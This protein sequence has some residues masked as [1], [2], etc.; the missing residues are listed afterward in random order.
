MPAK[1]Q[2]F[3]PA[4]FSYLYAEEPEMSEVTE[5]HILSLGSGTIDP[6]VTVVGVGGAGSNIVNALKEHV[7]GIETVAVNTDA[8]HLFALDTDKKILIGKS[9]TKCFSAHNPGIGTWAAMSSIKELEEALDGDVI[10]IIAGLGGGTGTGATPVIADIA[11]DRAITLALA[12]KPFS[13]EGEARSKTADEGLKAL[14]D[15]INSVIVFENDSLLK[16]SDLPF[17]RA[18]MEVPQKLIAGII[19]NVKDHL[20]MSFLSTLE[21]EIAEMFAGE[22]EDVGLVAPQPQVAERAMPVQFDETG[23]IDTRIVR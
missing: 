14:R 13:V 18:F 12:I 11:K 16:F 15:T 4:V 23:F 5:N 6:K 9:V 22:E 19:K 2:A 3:K 21:E 1:F 7:E 10:V 8:Q 20:S 17:N